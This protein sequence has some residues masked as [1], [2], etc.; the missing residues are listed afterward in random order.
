MSPPTAVPHQRARFRWAMTP[1]AGLGKT[2]RPPSMDSG[3]LSATEC[4]SL[5]PVHLSES[6]RS[7]HPF[8]PHRPVQMGGGNS[9]PPLVD[10][11]HE[12]FGRAA[13]SW[14]GSLP[15]QASRPA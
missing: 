11:D 8:R 4:T 9:G 3:G 1:L 2:L 13:V 10:S 7:G 6:Q 14:T 15:V 12:A 5:D